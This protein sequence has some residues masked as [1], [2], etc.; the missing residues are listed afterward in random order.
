M[1]LPDSAHIQ[2]KET[3]WQLRHRHCRGKGE[4]G[5]PAPLYTVAEALSALK[6]LRPVA[7][8]ET[9]APAE[10]VKVCFHDAG[11]ILGSAWL[12]VTVGG[13]GRPRALVF[14]GDLGM[15]GR[16]VLCDPNPVVPEADLLL[17]ESTYGD[18][19]HRSLP[20]TKDE[21][22][23]TL[24]RTRA[25]RVSRGSRSMST[26][27]WPMRRLSVNNWAG[28]TCSR[29][30]PTSTSPSE[31]NNRLFAQASLTATLTGQACQRRAT[32]TAVRQRSLLSARSAAAIPGS[33][34][35]SSRHCAATSSSPAHRPTPIPAR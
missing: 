14:S 16:P 29:R 12:E 28:P 35:L 30:T 3:E 18:R 13:E 7:Y 34:R 15:P 1:L 26:R 2:E 20:E 24:E 8:R 21:I 25:A 33:K 19:Q 6:L 17:I 11:H 23:A 32:A 31:A 10:A 22:V 9:L 5:I 4:R 27:R